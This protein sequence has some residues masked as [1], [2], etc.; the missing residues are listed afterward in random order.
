MSGTAVS[1]H[2]EDRQL[3]A[4]VNMTGEDW[5]NL[6]ADLDGVGLELEKCPLV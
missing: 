2:S 6:H 4:R 3:R 5:P 1:K